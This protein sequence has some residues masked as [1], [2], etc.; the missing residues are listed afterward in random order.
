[1]TSKTAL[2]LCAALLSACAEKAPVTAS[3]GA[4]EPA[5]AMIARGIAMPAG[6]KVDAGRT[7][8]FGT[9][10]TW[11]GRLSYSTKTSPEDVFEFLHKE[12]PN[13]GWAELAS[14]RSDS[15]VLTFT[16][17]N[18]NRIATIN[19]GR[20]SM[21]GSTEVDLVVAPKQAGKPGPLSARA[22]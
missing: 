22:R 12:M 19:I 14:M 15:S 9:D 4:A 18:T 16:S 20:G 3:Q 21:L 10:E 2:I 7:L 6:Y 17:D 11:T 1:M 5:M 13:F 8:I